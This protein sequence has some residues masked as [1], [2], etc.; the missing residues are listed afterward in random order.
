M[1]RILHFKNITFK[2]SYKWF[3]IDIHQQLQPL[4]ANYLAMFKG[5]PAFSLLGFSRFLLWTKEKIWGLWQLIA[6]FL[7]SPSAGLWA[8]RWKSTGFWT[9]WTEGGLQQLL[10]QTGGEGD[11]QPENMK[12]RYHGTSTCGK[13]IK[14]VGIATLWV[15]W[16]GGSVG[17]RVICLLVQSE[18][19]DNLQ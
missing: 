10:L 4:T 3:K 1:K 17:E 9:G 13:K 18:N 12:H 19:C 14:E 5:V 8:E 6:K 15:I 16:T 11:S 2:S 7:P